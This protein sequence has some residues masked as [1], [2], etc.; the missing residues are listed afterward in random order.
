LK[1][2]AATPKARLACVEIVH[3]AAG[4]TV[5]GEK[6]N[7][8]S[9]AKAGRDFEMS[10][11]LMPLSALREYI[12]IISHTDL[13][14]ANASKPQEVGGDH[15]RSS[16]VFLTASHAKMT[17]GAD[18]ELATSI[19]QLYAQRFGQ[20]TPLPSIQL[21]IEST[22]GAGACDYGY[23]CVY[24]DTI[25]WASP[26]D[27]L[28][29]TRDPRQVFESLFG[30]GG[31]PAQRFTRLKEK[32]SILDQLIRDAA[33][34]QR[35]LPA[36]DRNRLASYL[37]GIRELE[38]R[39]QSIESYNAT[40]VTRELPTAPL[41]VPDSFEEHVELMFD[42][43]ALAFQ[44]EI[45]RVSGFKM[46]RDV[47]QRVYPESGVKT[48][49]HTCSHHG[50]SG[51]KLAEFAKLNRYHV[52]KVASFLEKLKNTP[53]GDGNLLDHSLVLYGS[54]MGD[55]QVHNHIRVPIFLA[56]RANGKVKGNLHIVATDGAP[57]AN[58]LLTVLD[59][60]GMPE[61]KIGDSGDVFSI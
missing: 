24:S 45:T 34:L 47:C 58:V 28:P 3:G 2:T 39:I 37:D 49:F 15:F 17:E 46:S 23:S 43:Q 10:Q 1:K 5:E 36:G 19:D 42:L 48:S 44:A 51:E 55:S 33:R 9:P 26:T 60:L 56:G 18:I 59:K 57:M 21:S 14:P 53:D 27:P 16:A 30:D 31:T 40:D 7:Y 20:D 32:R 54:P 12:T 8:W 35:E 52:S 61:L 50:E 11:S 29:M 41:G 38:R 25:S 22:D 4:S 13:N 6:K